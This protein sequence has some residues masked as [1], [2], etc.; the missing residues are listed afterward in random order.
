MECKSAFDALYKVFGFSPGG[1]TVCEN[2]KFYETVDFNI[3]RVYDKDIDVDEAQ[4][5]IDDAQ[6]SFDFLLND[7]N[8]RIKD[9]S[10][11]ARHSTFRLIN[12]V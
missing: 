7:S 11:H 9:V 12:A 3:I 8:S 2:G 6:K 4:K 10:K 1:T 5:R